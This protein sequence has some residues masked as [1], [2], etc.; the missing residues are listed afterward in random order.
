MYVHIDIDC[1]S[2]DVLTNSWSVKLQ[3]GQPKVKTEWPRGKALDTLH[4]TATGLDL[5]PAWFLRLG[6]PAVYKPLTYLFNKSIATSMVRLKWKM[7]LSL[8]SR[9]YPRQKTVTITGLSQ[10]LQS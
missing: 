1:N 5:V 9:K 4:P 10:S 2:G 6:A 7:Q 8:L 3:T